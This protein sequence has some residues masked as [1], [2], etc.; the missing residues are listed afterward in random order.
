MLLQSGQLLSNAGSQASS[1]AYPL[2]VLSLTHSAALAGVVSFSR[3]AGLVAAALPAGLASDHWSRRRLM[4]GSDLLRL[5]ALGLLGGLIVSGAIAYWVIPLAALVEG[6]LSAFFRAA[7]PGALRAVVPPFQLPAAVGATTGRNAAVRLVGPPLGGALYGVAAALP[8]LVDAGSY[9]TST[10]SLL[11]MRTPFQGPRPDVDPTPR[12]RRL[13]EGF[14][15]LWRQPFL[16]TSA[17]LLG[18][19]NFTTPALLLVLVVIGRRGGQSAALVSGLVAVFGAAVLV[20]ALSA[21]WVIRVVPAKTV[22]RLELWAAVAVA[23]AVAWPS[24]YVL[25]AALVPTGLVIPASDSVVHGYR[26]ALTPDHLIGRVESARSLISMS[27]S[28]LGPLLAG[29]LLEVSARIALTAFL[30]VSVLAVIWVSL[31]PAIR[32]AP[33]LEELVRS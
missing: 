4:I 24:P 22:L 31:S 3:S 21:P 25:A 32:S 20:G 30:L 29:L 10:A 18:L 12:R 16:R 8:F 2:L 23:V 15:F 1:L 14:T 9:L 5:A 6:V 17:L 26:L 28:P 13:G 33:Q 27:I 19:G 7:S 11:A